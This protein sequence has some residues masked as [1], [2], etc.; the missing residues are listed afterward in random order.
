MENKMIIMSNKMSIWARV[1][2]MFRRYCK[3]KIAR[4]LIFSKLYNS[5]IQTK[6]IVQK[7]NKIKTKA[8]YS[9]QYLRIFKNRIITKGQCLTHFINLR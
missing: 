8:K 7:K 9:Y 6:I 5:K 4:K 1:I 3:I 2:K